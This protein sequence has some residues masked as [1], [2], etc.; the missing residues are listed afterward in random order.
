VA[1]ALILSSAAWRSS[2]KA[3]RV[4]MAHDGLSVLRW[5][6]I[7]TPMTAFSLSVPGRAGQCQGGPVSPRL[8]RASDLSIRQAMAGM[9]PS[10]LVHHERETVEAMPAPAWRSRSCSGA[11]RAS[12]FCGLNLEA[13]AAASVG[14]PSAAQK[15]FGS[16]FADDRL[17]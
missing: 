11:A 7:T 6:F 5:R 9:P 15:P 13:P 17:C 2:R 10:P 4:E 8:C 3:D 12:R 1:A 16:V 14:G